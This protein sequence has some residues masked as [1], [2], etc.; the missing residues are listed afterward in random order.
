M[1]GISR[2]EKKEAGLLDWEP[3][4]HEWPECP[5]CGQ[6]DPT[7]GPGG[8][9]KCRKKMTTIPAGYWWPGNTGELK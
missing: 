2:I 9:W 5:L 4:W 1:P 8:C 3:R 7:A 6:Q